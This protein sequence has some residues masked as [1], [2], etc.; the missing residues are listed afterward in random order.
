[1]CFRLATPCRELHEQ[2]SESL[3]AAYLHGLLQHGLASAREAAPAAAAGADGGVCLAALR[4]LSA[5]FSWSFSRGEGA[6]AAV[7]VL[8]L[9]GWPAGASVRSLQGCEDSAPPRLMHLAPASCALLLG[10]QR[11]AAGCGECSTL[12][13]LQLKWAT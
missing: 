5:I 3:E 2:C 10:L 13:D 7:P 6:G 11:A 4:L 1:M 12:G 8:W 9:V